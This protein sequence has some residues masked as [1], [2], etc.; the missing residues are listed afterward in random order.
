MADEK[1]DKQAFR[2]AYKAYQEAAASG[3]QWDALKYARE[4][5]EYGE[6]VY[7]PN[8]KNTATLLFNYGRLIPKKEEA[9]EILQDAVNRYEKLYGA[10]A[11]Q[12]IDPL[13]DLAANSAGVGT[14]GKARS[15]Y[16][17]ALEL[18]QVHYPG[19]KHMEGIIRLEMGKIALQE[20]QSRQ[21][22][23]HL[24]KAKSL[25]AAVP[26]NATVAQV[27]EADFLIGKYQMAKKNYAKATESLLASLDVYEE[28]APNSRS[29]MTNHAFLIRVYEEQGMRD[30]ATKHCRAIGAKSPVKPDQDYMPV[31][32]A[33]PV[34]PSSAQRAG[35]EGYAIVE[36]TVD[37][38]GFV[39][40]PTAVEVKGHN[41]FRDAS[42]EAVAKFRYAP[43]YKDGKPVDTEGVRYRFTYNL[44]N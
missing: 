12:M 4:A 39:K 37:K 26:G 3:K 35:R 11:E 8:H 21:A 15:I 2:T 38:D 24:N 22:L 5:Y 14:L 43:Q 33:S 20:A 36:L 18:A 25:L 42:L 29:T 10:D 34:Y 30:K 17:R 40:N 32:R 31:Y 16:R 19:D 7:G 6:K 44:R 41:G 1:S 27:A 28:Y 9:R 13:M 23:T